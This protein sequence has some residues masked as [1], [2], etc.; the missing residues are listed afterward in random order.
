MNQM[1][2]LPQS[3]LYFLQN[4]NV[5][6]T[7]ANQVATSGFTKNLESEEQ[8]ALGEGLG[9]GL[10]GGEGLGLEG[11]EKKQKQKIAKKDYLST[12]NIDELSQ[13]TTLET[14]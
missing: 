6:R 10:E 14:I 3:F 12:T 1:A 8:E 7:V 11:L 5:Q 4:Q 9:E 2:L 13:I